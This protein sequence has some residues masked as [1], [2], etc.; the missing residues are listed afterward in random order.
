[1][2]SDN[3]F[4]VVAY[5]GFKAE[6]NGLVLETSTSYDTAS[7]HNYDPAIV[8]SIDGSKVRLTYDQLWEIRRLISNM[9]DVVDRIPHKDNLYGGR[10]L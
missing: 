10:S 6:L 2:D 4:K 7:K 9:I 8:I 3:N 1:M 5:S